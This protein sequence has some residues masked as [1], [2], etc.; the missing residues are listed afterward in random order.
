MPRIRR[1]AWGSGIAQAAGEH[2]PA[3]S[4]PELAP[5]PVGTLWMGK[6]AFLQAGPTLAL[7]SCQR[8]L[9]CKPSAGHRSLLFQ[10]P[11]PSV[12]LASEGAVP[13]LG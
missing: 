11:C 6:A 12:A 1:L 9:P 10:H 13:A 7:S 5:Q 4:R 8:L 2:I 3:S